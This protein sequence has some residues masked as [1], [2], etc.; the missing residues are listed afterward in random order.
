MGV[1]LADK[2]GALRDQQNTAG[3]AVIDVLGHL[4]GDLPRQIGTQPGQQRRGNHRAGLEDIGAGRRLDAIGAD[5]PTI[6]V[7]I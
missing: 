1:V 5:R 7:A 4:G 2:P 6:D 3:R